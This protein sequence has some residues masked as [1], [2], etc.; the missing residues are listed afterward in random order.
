MTEYSGMDADGMF[1]SAEPPL[2]LAR[3]GFP[4]ER[5]T[6]QLAALIEENE[7]LR[8]RVRLLNKLLTQYEE[9]SRSQ[10]Y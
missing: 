5:L 3:Q 10:R 4:D 6:L 8:N 7:R 2:P 9:K 1:G